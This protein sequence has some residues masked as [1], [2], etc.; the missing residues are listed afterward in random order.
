MLLFADAEAEAIAYSE[1]V[2]RFA[3]DPISFGYIGT[4][5]E[6]PGNLLKHTMFEGA[7]TVLYKPKRMK[8]LKLEDD[9]SL[10]LQISDVLGG[11]G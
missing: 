9:R 4:W 10:E 3:S 7:K 2:A 1:L 5:K 8:W 11:S 6:Y